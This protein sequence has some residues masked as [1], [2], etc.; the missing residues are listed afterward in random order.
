M[1][2]KYVRNLNYSCFSDLQRAAKTLYLY[3]ESSV[4][5]TFIDHALEIIETNKGEIDL[6]LKSELI[7]IKKILDQK[8]TGDSKKCFQG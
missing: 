3:P 6:N 1:L 5:I 4:T 7:G 8:N 2:N